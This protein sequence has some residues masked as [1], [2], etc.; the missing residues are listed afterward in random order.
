MGSTTE[1]L[2]KMW[3][4]LRLSEEEE[5]DV[6]V[7]EDVLEEGVNRGSNCLVGRLIVDRVIAKSTVRGMLM[8]RWRPTGELSFKVMGENLFLLDFENPGDKFL[9]LE[10]RPWVVDGILFAIED[11][12]G[13]STP[14]SID[15]E[16]VAFW[17]RMYNLP[18]ACMSRVVGQKL[19]A[20]VGEVVEVDTNDDGMGWGEFL[21]VRIKVNVSKPLAKGRTLKVRGQAIWIAFQYERIPRFCFSC[22]VISHGRSGCQEGARKIMHG[23]EFEMQFGPWLRAGSPSRRQERGWGRTGGESSGTES[24]SLWRSE[25]QGREAREVKPGNRGKSGGESQSETDGTSVGYASNLKGDI[26]KSQ[27]FPS[28]ENM[29]LNGNYAK[30][31]VGAVF[32]N[33]VSS[34]RQG[35]DAG[36]KLKDSCMSGSQEV[37]EEIIW[38]F[39]AS[40]NMQEREVAGPSLDMQEGLRGNKEGNNTIH[41]TCKVNENFVQA[42]QGEKSREQKKKSVTSWKKRA[43]IGSGEKKE[44]VGI[45]SITGVRKA[46]SLANATESPS[47]QKKGKWNEDG[48]ESRAMDEAV[49]EEQPRQSQ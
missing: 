21:R 32:G 39:N 44:G 31:G 25:G 45:L 16:N 3:N 22:G 36:F 27:V 48:R 7:Q 28:G 41:G 20:T 11:F 49:A 40:P 24:P 8:R 26:P 5:S 37:N 15:F 29:A 35:G 13:I 30:E 10:G 4:K 14:A 12:D 38:G 43:R 33:Y 34:R 18:L 42:V 47:S 19:G 1:E 23:D 46:A 6:V 9:V 17:V 2:S